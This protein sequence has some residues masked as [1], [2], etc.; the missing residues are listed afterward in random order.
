M[1][2]LTALPLLCL[3][4]GC[5]TTR[6]YR[7]S[8]TNDT[9]SAI[10]I[11]LVKDGD[12]YQDQWAPPEIAVSQGRTPDSKLWAAIPAGRTADTG[13]VKG[14]FFPS[15]HAILRVYEGDLNLSGILAINRDQPNRMDIVLHP[16]LN[17]ITVTE[18]G[19]QL[20]AM[21]D[22]PKGPEPVEQ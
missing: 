16:G 22:T 18:K 1:R 15:S 12:P 8:V 10:T 13:P 11:G 7:V 14:R 4:V 2:T 17:H 20:E 21:H 9:P 3:L 5:A 6:T 19:A